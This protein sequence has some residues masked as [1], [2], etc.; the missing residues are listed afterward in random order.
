M[1]VPVQNSRRVVTTGGDPVSTL[2]HEFQLTDA[3]YLHVYADGVELVRGVDY[4]VSGI[5]DPAG[6]E[7]TLTEP[8]DWSADVWVLNV[9]YP[10]NQPSDVDQGG[11]FGARFENALDRMA[12]GLQTLDDRTK[13]TPKLA[14]TTSLDAAEV[15]FPPPSPDNVIGWDQFGQNL[16]NKGT[17][18]DI[19]VVVESVAAIN[20]VSN[21]I[22]A[23]I[24]VDAYM[25]EVL[26]VRA[27]INA[28]ASVAA[29]ITAVDVVNENIA[30]ILAV[31]GISADV[32]AVAGV[33]TDVAAVAANMA[34]L[35]GV[36]AKLDEIDGV[37]GSL[38]A[39]NAV[40][41][42]LADILA[43]PAATFD[44]AQAAEEAAAEAIEA[45]EGAWLAAVPIGNLADFPIDDVPAGYLKCD[46]S[47]FDPLVYPDLYTYLGTDVLPDFTD[48]VK[49]MSGPLA[50]A[51]GTTQEDAFQ[52][53]TFDGLVIKPGSG[54]GDGGSPKGSTALVGAPISDGVNG[55]PRTATETRVKSYI[56][57]TCIKAYSVFS[58]PAQVDLVAI[59]Q[60]Q[61][62]NHADIVELQETV[63][64]YLHVRDQ[65]V[66]GTNGQAIA[67]GD[68]VRV[69]NTVV[70]NGIAG[71][72][73]GGNA[74]TLPVGTYRVYIRVPGYAV[75]RHKAM[76][77]N[78]TSTAILLEG[79]SMHTEQ[80]QAIITDSVIMGVL[81][82]TAETVLEVV[83][84]TSGAASTGGGVAS[85][86]GSRPE[87][88]TEA[89]FWKVD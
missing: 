89:L 2:T 66:A 55:T 63:T 88:Y 48:R 62:V 81:T 77:R 23:V 65:R 79:A 24:G 87:I 59:E 46:G 42:D 58:D 60:A 38:N 53:F 85:N 8:L 36:H 51:V 54:I 39:I 86:F 7:V 67:A 30:S 52:G 61:A 31:E 3:S 32:T 74:V 26:V 71:A 37:Y 18:P 72:T 41:A 43:A 27:N 25:A 83:H 5:G 50:G 78:K 12:L 16:E 22:G 82:L 1:T 6:Y 17:L 84:T 20:N 10:I 19:S 34:A 29:S 9:E 69:L 14:L 47:A 80:T 57:I 64:H 49:R 13:R 4:S 68:N 44:N 33:A 11:Q 40:Y 45:V 15:A 73:L 21:N 70:T 76:L 75:V 28:V 35:T 56:V